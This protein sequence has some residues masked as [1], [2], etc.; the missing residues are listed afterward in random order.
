VLTIA[1]SLVQKGVTIVC[2]LH[3]PNMAF[4]FGDDILFVHDQQIER[5]EVNKPWDSPLLKIVIPSF[6]A[7]PYGDTSFIVPQ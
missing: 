2:A 5:D 4:L 6:Q 7:V 3:D 1:K